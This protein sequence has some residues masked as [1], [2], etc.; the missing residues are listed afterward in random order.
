ML[1]RHEGFCSTEFDSGYLVI[2]A[3]T[4][5]IYVLHD[6]FFTV[7]NTTFVHKVQR[8][9]LQKTPLEHPLPELAK[10][11]LCRDIKSVSELYGQMYFMS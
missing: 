4:N 1:T 6:L 8:Q 10:I 2:A 11:Y 5:V 7:S 9:S 3:I